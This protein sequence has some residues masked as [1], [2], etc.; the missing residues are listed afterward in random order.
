M[1]NWDYSE[2]FHLVTGL[3]L[4]TVSDSPDRVFEGLFRFSGAFMM[5]FCEPVEQSG[6]FRIVWSSQPVGMRQLADLWDEYD[7]PLLSMIDRAGSRFY[8]QVS[9][10]KAADAQLESSS[11][12]IRSI[13]T[14]PVLYQNTFR[15]FLGFA[16]TE[17]MNITPEEIKILEL[18]T[19]LLGQGWADSDQLLSWQRQLKNLTTIN[20]IYSTLHYTMSEEAIINS[21]VGSILEQDGISGCV[22]K[23]HDHGKD[24]YI[25]TW[26][27]YPENVHEYT[28]PFSSRSAKM[29]ESGTVTEATR[30]PYSCIEIGPFRGVSFLLKIQDQELG[31]L[32]VFTRNQV[33]AEKKAPFSTDQILLLQEL[34]FHTSIALEHCRFYTESQKLARLNRDRVWKF[35]LIY[36][37]S[38]LFKETMSIEQ[39]LHLILTAITLGDGMGFNRAVLLMIDEKDN[40]LHGMM[41]IGPSSGD[42]ANRIWTN[43]H[44]EERPYQEWIVH[45]MQSKSYLNSDFHREILHVVLPLSGPANVFTDTVL[46]RKTQHVSVEDSA[47]RC[48]IQ[49][50]HFFRGVEF[51]TVPLMSGERILGVIAVDNFYNRQPIFPE[52]IRMLALFAGHA[53]VSIELSSLYFQMKEL[54]GKLEMT[55][56][57]LEQ[58]E[59]LTA[60][61]ELSALMA[62]EI[63][64]P[65]VAIGGFA[66]RLHALV[67]QHSPD[68]GTTYTDI[69]IK[70]VD[71]LEK[72]LHNI[73][74]FAREARTDFE[75]VKLN[76][77]LAEIIFLYESEL[78]SQKIGLHKELSRDLPEI[79]VDKNGL[80]QVM[81]NLINNAIQAMKDGG[82]LTVRSFIEHDEGEQVCLEIS[83]TGGG[84]ESEIVSNIFNPFFTTKEK[85]IGLGL[86]LALKIVERNKGSLRL[87][88]R[89]GQGVTFK[90]RFPKEI[91]GHTHPGPLEAEVDRDDHKSDF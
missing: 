12:K 20:T 29:N 62:H 23:V 39:R 21:L 65:L 18:L 88:N 34:C 6:D 83:D 38:Y 24:A 50:T 54:T 80:K 73:L 9:V 11:D 82:L 84:I 40:A 49:L 27:E 31:V 75:P 43:L 35:S 2:I 72:I 70:E 66:R 36:E 8:E 13:L 78:R 44:R 41:G 60:L 3:R 26:G 33:L 74:Q 57:Q 58:H 90:I 15:G 47:T 85:G 87:I 7:Q 1:V 19:L 71:R 22:L 89:Y 51:A 59:K 77:I 5:V 42:E 61:G 56:Q 69:I 55:H 4:E 91:A 64:N 48:P 17:G 16:W 30:L 63:R 81:I 28:P 46:E 10:H 14:V 79:M 67:L 45:I 32:F 86:P 25:M 52:D 53:G 37:I 76:D 68:I